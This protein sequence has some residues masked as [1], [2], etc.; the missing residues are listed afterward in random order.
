MGLARLDE[1]LKKMGHK[2]GSG[3]DL[4]A[5]AKKHGTI[6]HWTAYRGTVLLHGIYKLTEFLSAMMKKYPVS[7]QNATVAPFAKGY[8][9]KFKLNE[10]PDV[11]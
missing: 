6:L 3:G 10:Y 7:L 2:K 9:V 4:H 5:L 8:K 11:D 1:A